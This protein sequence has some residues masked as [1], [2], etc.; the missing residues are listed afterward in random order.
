[1]NDP[2]VLMA[3]A[4]TLLTACILGVRN[5]T[6]GQTRVSRRPDRV[7]RKIQGTQDPKQLRNLFRKWKNPEIRRP[8]GRMPSR[9]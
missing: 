2:V 9:P 6:A 5:M 7:V 1:M 4:C 8:A 3:L